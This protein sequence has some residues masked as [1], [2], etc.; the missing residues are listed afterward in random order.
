MRWIANLS[1]FVGIGLALGLT[2]KLIQ[3]VRLEMRKLEDE[4]MRRHLGRYDSDSC[5]RWWG[6]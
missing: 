2:I 4:E 3:S 5:D 6:H 1:L